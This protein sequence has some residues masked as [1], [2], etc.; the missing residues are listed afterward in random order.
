MENIELNDYFELIASI[1][2]DGY[3]MRLAKSKNKPSISIE[4]EQKLILLIQGGGAECDEAKVN[5][6][7][8]YSGFL[9]LV[10][11][12]Y[13]HRGLIQ[14]E[15]I[16]AGIKGLIKAA[17]KYDASR[18]FKFMSYAV[19]W[20]RHYMARGIAERLGG[21]PAGE[22]AGTVAEEHVNTQENEE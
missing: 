1:P 16:M 8:A 6:V 5:L 11:R 4:E 22:A 2:R 12:R 14:S 13:A 17:E 3:R 20:V 15:L 18:G 19:W 21:K 7:S 9:Y 10:S